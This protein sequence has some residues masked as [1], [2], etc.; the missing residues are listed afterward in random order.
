MANGTRLFMDMNM[1]SGTDLGILWIS[2]TNILHK[3]KLKALK[4]FYNKKTKSFESVKVVSKSK[5]SVLPLDGFW[6]IDS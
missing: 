6:N 1:D 2:L 5:M 4:D 3:K